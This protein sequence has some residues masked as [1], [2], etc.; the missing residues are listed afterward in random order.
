MSIRYGR[1]VLIAVLMQSAIG[2]ISQTAGFT[3]VDTVCVNEPV[4][5][6][7]TAVNATNYFWN[8]CSGGS[9]STPTG[10]NIGNPGN[11]L[12]YP[13]FSDIVEEN[14]NFY[15]FVSNNWPGGLIRL[16]FGNSLLNTPTPVSLGTVGG[17]V[18]N[19]IQSLQVVKNEGKWYVI[20]V[21]GHSSSGIVSRVIKIELGTNIT[22][23]SPTGTNWGN[24][25]NLAYPVDLHLFQ[26]GSRWYGLTLNAENSTLTRFDFTNSFDNTPTA[27]NLGN[28][29][30]NFSYPT[31]IYAIKENNNWHVFVTNDEP[32]PN[33]I[34][35][36]FGVSLLNTPVPVNLG[37][38][39]GALNKT[40]D[41]VFLKECGAITAF[42][43]NGA[44][45]DQLVRLEFGNDLLSAPKGVNL[46]NIGNL[47]FPHSI[48]KF[49][50]VGS[51]MYAF[52]TNVYSNSITRLQF[53]GCNNAS[54]P[55]SSAPSPPLF[56]YNA[57]G[58]YTVTQTIDIGLPTQAVTCRT[59]VVIDK[60]PHYPVKNIT[61]CAG[62][63]VKLGAS[64]QT[65]SYV[66][67]DGAVSDSIFV[68]TPGYHWVETQRQGCSNRD[69]FLV[70]VTPAPNVNLGNDTLI[71]DAAS[72]MLDAGNSGSSFL[73]NTGS[74]SQSISITTPGEYIVNVTTGICVRSDTVQVEL[75]GLKSSDFIFRQ[76]VCDGRAVTY[77]AQ[78]PGYTTIDWDFGDGN[79][80][81]GVKDAVHN[82]T[83]FGTYNVVMQVT[84]NG[85]NT[86]VTKRV[87]I[88]MGSDPQL[89]ITP[90]TTIC[91]NST[92]QLRA[93]RGLNYC[94]YPS[95]FLDN[96]S[97]SSPVTSTTSNITYY[98]R[99][100][101]MGANIVVNGDFSQGNTGFNSDYNFTLSNNAAGQ[102][103]VAATPAG[104]SSGINS[105]CRDHSSGTGNMLL[106]SSAPVANQVL[107][108]QK[109]PV[110][111]FTNYAFSAWVQSIV[112]N[113]TANLRFAINGR[114]IDAPILSQAQ[115]CT[116]SEQFITWTAGDT[117]EAELAIVNLNTGT[118]N[119]YFA[120]DD[121]SF[122]EVFLREDSV[123]VLVEAPVVT[124][125]A[126]T[127]VCVGQ[128][129]QLVAGGA[130]QYL[131]SP[132]TGLSATDI[133]NPVA[134]SATLIAY[135]VTGT[136]AAGC[137]AKDTVVLSTYP[138]AVVTVHA[139]T[140]ICKNTTLPVWASGGISYQW[141]PASLVN[142]PATATPILSPAAGT[143]FHVS[144]TDAN[145][146]LYK[147]SIQV[148]I[149][150]DPVFS[151]NAPL[152]SCLND[153]I[154]LLATGGDVYTWLP[155][156]GMDNPS[157]AS[158]RI[159]PGSTVNYSVTITESKCNESATL[160]TR[161]NV[162]PLPDVR[163]VKS[164]DIDCSY[165]QAVL[166]ARGARTYTWMPAV[167]LSNAFVSSPVAH[168]KT[169][170]TYIVAG[171]D[172]AGCTNYDSV[173]VMVV[174]AN[175]SG[176]LMPSA[177]TPNNDG[178]ND[179]YGVKYWGVINNIEFSIFDRW[180][181]R[182][183]YSK[184]PAACWDGTYKGE[185]QP[186]GVYV[187]MIKASTDCEDPVFRKGT[188]MLIR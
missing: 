33:L 107:W 164:N 68:S 109:V 161:V 115:L 84:Y 126:D 6:Q 132:S 11:L 171:T 116:W 136:T 52:I 62:D 137:I 26:E 185:K 100:Q 70:T 130:Q 82:Y 92:K 97:I 64:S 32:N 38:P 4:A 117:T 19:T 158:P 58:I 145:S 56:S 178:L 94:W 80:A 9:F 162:L 65:G 103:G 30:N 59:I 74:T 35:L 179:C 120:L 83:A 25:G 17:V 124:A 149:I 166:Q 24:L 63:S 150:P 22:N 121:I 144:V 12:S 5:I 72:F 139:D 53:G 54:L 67:N 101:V 111:P 89:V 138:K 42:A 51:D 23:A 174:K 13:V 167:N 180:G 14:G 114:V 186:G 47:N 182:V 123:T 105:N 128:P 118:G 113:S 71:C 183:F 69:S 50:R 2:A 173:T 133:A 78:L 177:F 96:P 143:L 73:W 60:L 55:S 48:S 148:D 98:L 175:P 99:S 90:D 93:A 181:V 122:A 95:D 46:G 154:T 40:R 7:N 131:W 8:F 169:T 108:K 91:F 61:I 102:Y 88:G 39:N 134:T 156:I 44:T 125:N 159:A 146:C 152:T 170:T 75:Y 184:D 1:L 155:A 27:Q 104:W 129:V 187:Y 176:Y 153:T 36:D 160:Y 81:S 147:D 57:P 172:R 16:D 112:V 188:F 141:S 106:V 165:G 79:T 34:R 168:P 76:D 15:L 110:T 10:V 41:I 66:W 3:M 49:F 86:A 135:E 157:S 163:V 31:G 127:I 20:M 18:I 87:T 43:V 21:G 77:S 45:Y 140:A 28:P 151:V 29:G 142:D 119:S 37:N 85:C